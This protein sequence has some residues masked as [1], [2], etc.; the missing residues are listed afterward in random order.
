MKNFTQD[1]QHPGSYSNKMLSKYKFRA[2]LLH[3]PVWF[4]TV[5]NYKCAKIFISIGEE[6]TIKQK[7]PNIPT[8]YL[9][10]FQAEIQTGDL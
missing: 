10:R 8:D 5:G 1:R 9:L 3:H 4:G 7:P 6:P 2:L